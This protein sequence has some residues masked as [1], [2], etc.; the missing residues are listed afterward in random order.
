MNFKIKICH[1]VQRSEGRHVPPAFFLFDVNVVAR[2]HFGAEN[3][4]EIVII[5]DPVRAD[6]RGK[7]KQRKWPAL[8]HI[9]NVL[10]FVLGRKNEYIY[11]TLSRFS[12][13]HNASE[14]AFP[15]SVQFT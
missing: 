15:N 12:A 6:E 8:I 3:L 9:R 7:T 13:F 10:R 4:Y 1:P 5:I 11:C 2:Q 14:C